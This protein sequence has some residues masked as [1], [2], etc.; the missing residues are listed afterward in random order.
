MTGVKIIAKGASF[1]TK[2]FAVFSSPV[3]AGLLGVYMGGDGA[4]RN[5]AENGTIAAT[6]GTPTRLDGRTTSVDKDNYIDTGI[7]PDTQESTIIVVTKRFRGSAYSEPFGGWTNTTSSA[8]AILG[9]GV[10]LQPTGTVAGILNVYSASAGTSAT[11]TATL[12]V[13]AGIPNPSAT[14]DLGVWRCLCQRVSSTNNHLQDLTAGTSNTFTYTGD[15]KPDVRGV[16]PFAIGKPNSA[17]LDITGKS[18]IMIAFYFNRALTDDE[19]NKM[20]AYC[21]GFASRSGVTYPV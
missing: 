6:V 18:H 1:I 14:P 19:V 5:F 7:L 15:F 12:I 21:T 2:N 4:L 11:A 13:D 9:R 17:S 16:R 20:H 8:A 3:S 10:V